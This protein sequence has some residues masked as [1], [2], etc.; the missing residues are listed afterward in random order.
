MNGPIATIL[1]VDDEDMVRDIA[2]RTL[3]RFGHETV[4][5][6][7][8]EAAL[9]ALA[10]HEEIGL[11]LIDA[12]MPGMS[13]LEVFAEIKRRGYVMPVVLMSG[14]VGEQLETNELFAALSGFV[15]KPFRSKQLLDAVHIALDG[16]R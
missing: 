16:P 2:C 5:V 1:V 14:Y 7:D 15:K 13:G 8:G 12:S 6:E 11:V 10:E 3:T 9:A 4:P